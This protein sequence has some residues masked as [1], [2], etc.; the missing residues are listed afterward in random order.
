MMK[1]KLS[2]VLAV[3]LAVAAALAAADV[4]AERKYE[5]P[6]ESIV[7]ADRLRSPLGT[8]ELYDGMPTKKTAAA[9][10]DQLYFLRAVDV[11]LNF[12]PA[13]SIEAIRRGQIEIGADSSNKVIVF[14]DLMDS[15]PLF[16]TGNTDTVYAL[17]V[18]DLQKD[19]PTVIEIPKGAGPGTLDDAFHRFVVDMGSPGP[20]RGR[21]GY[22]IILPPDYKGDLKPTPNSMK[23]N[24][25]V[26]VRIGGKLRAAWIAQSP[27]YINWLILRG[28]LVDGKP[29]AA[30]AMWRNGLKIYPLAQ[31]DNPLKME[32]ING[33]NRHFNTILPTDLSFYEYLDTIIQK[34]PLAFI[35]AELRGQAAAIGIARGD[36][37]AP[38][39][40]QRHLLEQALAFA[41]AASRTLAFRP[42]DPRA[43]IFPDREWY[44]AFVGKDNRW[45]GGDG[46]RGRD[47]DV[48]TAFFYIGTVNTPAMAIE[49]PG[50]GSNY[51][52]AFTDRN[53][54]ILKGRENYR[55][56][57]PAN[58]PA[59]DF[60]SVV[61]YD[62]MTR[63]QLQTSQ[64]FPSINS[65]RDKDK[66][67]YNGDGSIDLYFG[68]KPP[69]GKEGNWIQTVPGKSW[70]TVLRLYGPLK[71]W[72][73]Q[74]W[75]PGDIEPVK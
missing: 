45:L 67:G 28:F 8:F 59:K 12:Q 70:F 52:M 47:L 73:D 3:S 32:Y 15:R 27:S 10:Y 65:N 21:G 63:S 61:V 30:A 13:V 68:P 72:F 36:K 16:L 14:D 19:G 29:D 50:V 57:L 20:D 46:R 4:A 43:R 74:S 75:K 31:A 64:P 66:L 17:A 54:D 38:N 49:I 60:W 35:D 5:P 48:R 9:I 42:R 26:K 58:V 18:L 69:Q 25:S 34:E 62:T 56:H 11:F 37:F 71:P 22:Y 7:V 2:K 24:S 1:N 23:D 44:L 53:G 41:N 51:G 55:L 40:K 6:P 39:A 33:S